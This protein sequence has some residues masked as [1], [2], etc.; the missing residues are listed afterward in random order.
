MENKRHENGFQWGHEVEGPIEHTGYGLRTLHR[1]ETVHGERANFIRLVLEY[2]K[3]DFCNQKLVRVENSWRYLDNSLCSAT[4]KYQLFVK[5]W[6]NVA[7]LRFKEMLRLLPPPS[8][9]LLIP[10]MAPTYV[11]V[12]RPGGGIHLDKL[13]R[14]AEMRN[15]PT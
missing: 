9:R 11:P 7:R 8:T 13:F 4:L 3:A 5:N 14:V 2:I 15:L 6:R 1:D 10:N 12:G